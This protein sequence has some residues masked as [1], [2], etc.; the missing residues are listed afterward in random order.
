M[1]F[2]PISLIHGLYNIVEKLLSS[3]LHTVMTALINPH[4]ITF[5]SGRKILDGFII[6]N[7]VIHCIK[8]GG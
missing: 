3:K 5:I 6:I 1:E 2:K 8:K 4:Q 7:K